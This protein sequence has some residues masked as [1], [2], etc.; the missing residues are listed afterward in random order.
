[1]PYLDKDKIDTTVKDVSKITEPGQLNFVISIII[2]DEWKK[3]PSYNTIFVLE[4]E[5]VTN[6]EKCHFLKDLYR[7]I[8]NRDITFSHIRTAAAQAYREFYRRVASVYETVKMVENGDI[9]GDVVAG[10]RKRLD[11]AVKKV[12]EK[13]AK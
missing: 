13:D 10:L 12:K 9:Y 11:E 6:P 4:H 3:N 1:M 8:E 5:L 7:K 2:R